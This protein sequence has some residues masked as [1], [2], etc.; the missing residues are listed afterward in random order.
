MNETFLYQIFIIP[1]VSACLWSASTES[2]D[3]TNDT[4]LLVV[5]PVVSGEVEDESKTPFQFEFLEGGMN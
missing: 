2:A 4:F 1:A 5:V 3:A